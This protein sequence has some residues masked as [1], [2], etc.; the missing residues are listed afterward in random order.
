MKQAWRIGMRGRIQFSLNP[1]VDD[2]AGRKPVAEQKPG[3]KP[4]PRKAG[5]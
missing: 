2:N 4:R 1:D 5:Q 3:Q